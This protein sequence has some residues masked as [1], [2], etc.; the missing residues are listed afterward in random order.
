MSR[1]TRRQILGTLSAGAALTL[2]GCSGGGDESGDGTETTTEMGGTT[3]EAMTDGEMTTEEM[4]DEETTTM[5]SMASVRVA[6]LSP[7]APNVDVYVDGT[8]VLEDVAYE[9][10]GSYM[11]L[12]TGSHDIEITAAGDADTVVYDQSLELAA[13]TYTLA[14]VGELNSE[15]TEFQVLALTDDVSD[16]G[17]DSARIKLVHASPD[18]PAVDVTL[19]SNG[20]A[21]FDG[22]AFT[23]TSETTV[24]GGDYT[25]DVRGDTESNDGEVQASFDVSPESGGAYTAFAIG[26][27]TP[28]DE[29]G[30]A[31][32]TLS[33]VR[34]DDMGM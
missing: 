30:D 10:V 5:E 19:A 18:A 12:S 8:A 11:S 27:L 31:S 23:E 28:D 24:P 26:Y 2:A 25:L 20:D 17:D 16:P 9:T 21:V 34:D 29:D 4:T 6:H 22:V 1:K 7:D 32:F 15:D 13:E 33:V 14:A 3:T